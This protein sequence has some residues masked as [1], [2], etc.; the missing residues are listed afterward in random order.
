MSS[1][2]W[3]T[4]SFRYK[5]GSGPLLVIAVV[6]LGTLRSSAEE[7]EGSAM[8]RKIKLSVCLIWRPYSFGLQQNC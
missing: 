3:R 4:A 8:H 1:P 7:A 6:K 5:P 2:V